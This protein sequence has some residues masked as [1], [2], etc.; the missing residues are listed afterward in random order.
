MH[1]NARL[2][3]ICSNLVGFRSISG[4]R[5]AADDCLSYAA[6]LLGQVGMHIERHE[7]GGFPSLVATSRPGRRPRLLLQAHIDVVPGSERQFELRRDEDKLYGRGMFDMKYA[8]ACFLLAV[9]ELGAGLQDYDFGI[10][11]TS[12][13]ETGGEHG[14]RYLLEQGYASEVCFL[15][16]GGDNWRIEMAAK[17][18]WR[19]QLT[20]RGV[21]AHGSRPWDGDNAI[22]KLLS[23]VRAATALAPVGSHT[24]TTVTPTLIHGGVADNQVPAA[25]YATLDIRFLNNRAYNDIS[26]R[27]EQLAEEHGIGLVTDLL[28]EPTE[29]DVTLPI[30]QTWDQVV[31]EIRGDN[32]PDGYALSF[33]ASD[34]RFFAAKGIPTIVTR[35]D[36]GGMHSEQEWISEPSLYDFYR[37]IRRYIDLVGGP[38][39]NQ[40]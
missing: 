9:E 5:Q 11:L 39:S 27:L 10:M 23:F 1:T 19:V 28:I 38:E 15:P 7:S 32:A 4:Q 33:G 6:E 12:D 35:P 30:V 2:I 16:D 31:R 40:P 22:L 8:A 18:S 20:A 24:D 36:G 37:C 34:A 13:E 17:G 29:L 3:D 21:T 25:A 14:V 26:L